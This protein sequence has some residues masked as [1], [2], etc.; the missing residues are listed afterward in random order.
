MECPNGCSVSMK[1][2][3]VDRIL[4][5]AGE[6]VV[7]RGLK[8]HICPECGCETMPLKSARIVERVLGGQM[9]PV[10]QFAAPLFQAVQPV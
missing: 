3:R 8:M 4:Y 10:G 9:E 2:V 7:I 6:P 5:R 1:T